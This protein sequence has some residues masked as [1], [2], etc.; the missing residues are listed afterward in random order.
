M[1]M[2]D[3]ADGMAFQE[4]LIDVQNNVQDTLMYQWT[5][6]STNDNSTRS[7]Q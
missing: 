2:N 1:H 6:P 5:A 3:I 4:E 7:L